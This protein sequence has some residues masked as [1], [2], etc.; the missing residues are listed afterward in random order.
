MI[1]QVWFNLQE[2]ASPMRI[3]LDVGKAHL[4]KPFFSR[5][6]PHPGLASVQVSPLS[7]N[8]VSCLLSP[9]GASIS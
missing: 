3:S 7:P 1:L 6:F 4:W 9:N 5:S 2:H 8:D